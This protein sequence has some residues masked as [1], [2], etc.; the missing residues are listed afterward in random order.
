MSAIADALSCG[1]TL[2]PY[3]KEMSAVADPSS[4]NYNILEMF[5]K[6]I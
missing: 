6:L 1:V 2:H 4:L 3:Y 5:N